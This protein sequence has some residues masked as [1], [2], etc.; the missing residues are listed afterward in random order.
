MTSRLYDDIPRAAVFDVVGSE[1]DYQE[2]KWNPETTTS[3][4]RHSVAEYLLY[5]EHHV[6]VAR[7]LLSTLPS[8]QSEDQGL[9]HIRK[10][11]ALGVR[12]MMQNGAPRRAGF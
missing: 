12:T 4:G 8:P 9:E 3:G 10:I 7:T 6:S 5:I 1:L 2:T 11:T